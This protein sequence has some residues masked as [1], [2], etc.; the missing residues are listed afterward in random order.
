MASPDDDDTARQAP[1]PVRWDT[2]HD[3]G[4][5]SPA[6]QEALQAQAAADALGALDSDEA[7]IFERHLAICAHCRRLSDGFRHTVSYL[8]DLVHPVVAPP[9]LKAR[10]LAAIHQEATPRAG[11][12][13]NAVRPVHQTPGA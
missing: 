1:S 13:A 9:A 7:A 5:L 10:V 8:P 11:G 3:P 2:P 12:D 6:Q 4:A